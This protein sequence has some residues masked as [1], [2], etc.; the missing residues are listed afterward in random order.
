[1][2][3]RPTFLLAVLFAL[4][5][6]AAREEKK[7][8]LDD[9]RKIQTLSQEAYSLYQG[10]EH[11]KSNERFREILAMIPAPAGP[12]QDQRLANIHYNM[13]LNHYF[14][15]IKKEALDSLA[16]AVLHGFWN[17]EFLARDTT[18]KDLRGDKEY[19]AILERCRRATAEMAFGLKDL[20][21]NE[22]KKEDH[23]GKVLI[24][25]VWG[26]W[27]PPCRAEIPHFIKLQEKY[28]KDGLRVIGLTWE[29]RPPD[30]S[31]KAKVETFAKGAGM[32]YPVALLTE[33][34]LASIHPRVEAFPTTFF[35]GR[36]GLVASRLMGLA[37]YEELEAKVRPLLA[38][39]PAA[40]AG[41]KQ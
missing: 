38:A 25:D 31:V 23:Q 19:Q 16:K 36:D 9:V 22:I 10:K 37:G 5:G 18:M 12:P 28:G 14:L 4:S 15:G 8:T 7:L 20:A 3:T 1:M 32:N 41:T 29:K 35:I 30:E 34:L 26:T 2:K 6:L 39:K 33:G 21:G 17:H 24:L 13:A 27:C 40:G 11:A